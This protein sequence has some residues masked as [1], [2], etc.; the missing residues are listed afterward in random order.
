MVAFQMSKDELKYEID[1]ILD[2]FSENA[3][4]NL[5]AFLKQLKAKDNTTLFDATHLNKILAEDKELLEKLA[6]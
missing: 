6:Q 2:H 5:L 4:E 3:L 1:K